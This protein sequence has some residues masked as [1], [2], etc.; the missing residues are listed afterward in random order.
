MAKINGSV[1]KNTSKYSCYLEA[2]ESNVDNINNRSTVTVKLHIVRTKYG[3]QTSNKYSGGI[4]IDGTLFSYEYTPN[5]GAGTS[6]DVVIATASKVVTHNADGTKSCSVSGV[7]NTS[8]TYSCGTASSSGTLTLSSIPR[9]SKITASNANIGQAV[10]IIINK[11]V[12]S[13][14]T[15][16]KYKFANQTAYTTIAEKIVNSTYALDIPDSFYDLIPNSQT[17]TLTIQAITYSGNTQIGNATYATC[18]I[19]T[20][21]NECSPI[22]ANAN[23]IDTV[24]KCTA[25]TGS[26]KRWIKY[27]SR[28]QFTW[29]AEAR[30]SAVLTS[31]KISGNEVSSPYTAGNWNDVN[32]LLVTD[33]RNY[34]QE[35][36]FNSTNGYEVV[37]YFRPTIVANGARE[38]S[39]SDNVIVDFSGSFYNGYFDVE[40]QHQNGITVSFRYRV[41]GSEE[42]INVEAPI[43]TTINGNT[44][45]A[46]NVS[47]G[48]LF[49]YKNAYDIQ[50]MVT[51]SLGE[52]SYYSIPVTAGIPATNTYKDSEGNYY[53]DVNGTYLQNGEKL[54]HAKAL[55]QTSFANKGS[56][57][58]VANAQ[59][60]IPFDNEDVNI[61][62]GITRQNGSEFVVGEGI[63]Y[64]KISGWIGFSPPYAGNTPVVSFIKN[65]TTILQIGNTK[66]TAWANGGIALSDYYIPVQ[67]GDIISV[68]FHP[69]LTNGGTTGYIR[70]FSY[71]MAE[72][73]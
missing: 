25:L 46:S 33:S 13:Y 52:V 54:I 36:W 57:L 34:F 68:K 18:T 10:Q 7:W 71:V 29:T 17:G 16:L 41:K 51:D 37:Q 53:F 1:T 5:W 30:K 43:V 26:N 63:E 12:S 73:M 66:T 72:A 38:S 23:A 15:T 22:I 11:N 28:P 4:N 32:Y 24:A 69:N 14:T 45:S 64:I 8:G 40:E 61:G 19:S 31:Q 21:E 39:I 50:M 59:N 20:V 47:L 65:G 9:E 42:W 3:W 6:G 70:R 58:N 67:K 27:I 48:E 2:Y 55:I 56:T 35:Y 60:N 44:F 62:N 49:N